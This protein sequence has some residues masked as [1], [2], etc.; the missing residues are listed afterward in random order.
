MFAVYIIPMCEWLSGW[1]TPQ[2]LWL[3]FEW[4][5]SQGV[6]GYGFWLLYHTTISMTTVWVTSDLVVLWFQWLQGFHG[7]DRAWFVCDVPC[8]PHHMTGSRLVNMR[9]WKI[10][11]GSRGDKILIERLKWGLSSTYD[12]DVVDIVFI[13][14]GVHH[15]MISVL[16]N[17][18]LS[19]ILS[20]AKEV[21]EI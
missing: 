7:C 19:Q 8:S 21:Y 11:V 10:F 16:Y 3:W 18:S 5:H 14:I 1:V 4:R 15:I 9:N 13:C 12:G 17:Q 2:L 6:Y 20:F